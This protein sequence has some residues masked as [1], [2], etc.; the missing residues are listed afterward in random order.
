MKGTRLAVIL[1]IALLMPASVAKVKQTYTDPRDGK[2]YEIVTIGRQTWLAENLACKP[3][4]GKYW[5]FADDEKYATTYGYLYDWEAACQSCPPG[6]HL[7]SQA[8]WR[9]MAAFLGG[10]AVAGGKLKEK[11]TAHWRAPNTAATNETG[12]TALPGGHRGHVSDDIFNDLY[13]IGHWWSA[14]E[15]SPRSAWFVLMLHHRPGIHFST[16]PKK[17]A[18]SVRCLKN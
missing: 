15:S 10:E 12:F 6:W 16:Y 3:A 1:G 5:A 2:A 7:P 13:D 4:K 14:T 17:V 8:E 11:G 9:E 18:F